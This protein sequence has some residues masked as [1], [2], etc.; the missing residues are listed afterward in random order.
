[1][2]KLLGKRTSN[3]SLDSSQSE[4]V[5]FKAFKLDDAGTQILVPGIKNRLNERSSCDSS[6]FSD[7]S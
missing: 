3:R 2:N 1:M 7:E 6:D 4:K 5:S